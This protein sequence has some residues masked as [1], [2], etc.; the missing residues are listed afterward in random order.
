MKLINKSWYRMS[1]PHEGDIFYPVF[2][3]DN[4]HMLV[5]GQQH[6]IAKNA[7]ATFAIAIMPNQ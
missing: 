7:G 2:I 1:H 4:K 6:E 5:D 3:V